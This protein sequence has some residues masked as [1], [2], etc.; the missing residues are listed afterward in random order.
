MRL[1]KYQILNRVKS[2]VNINKSSAPP[3]DIGVTGPVMS[4]L[5]ISNRW[6]AFYLSG[7]DRKGLRTIF[8][9][10][11]SV[12]TQRG[13]TSSLGIAFSSMDSLCT[14][15]APKCARRKCHKACSLLAAFSL[16][17]SPPSDASA[18][19]LPCADHICKMYSPLTSLR[20]TPSPSSRPNNAPPV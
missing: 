17:S 10:M 19:T 1:I 16:S 18:L 9:Y 6:V 4:L 14:A 20:V 8:L 15:S 13:T 3:S 7:R 5:T 11:H 12:Q 2:S